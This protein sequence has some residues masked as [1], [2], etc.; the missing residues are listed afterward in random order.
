MRGGSRVSSTSGSG[1]PG[2]DSAS[3]GCARRPNG[4][5]GSRPRCLIALA[6]SPRAADVGGEAELVGELADLVV[7]VALVEAQPLR[8]LVRRAE[9][10]QPGSL[11]SVVARHLEVVAVGSVDRDADRDSVR[12]RS[13]GSAW[14]HACARSVGFGPVFSPPSGAFVI[15]PSIAS[16]S[17]SIPFSSS[18]ASS[19]R[20][21][22]QNTPASV[23]SWKRRWA[24]LK[25][26]VA[27]RVPLAARRGDQPLQRNSTAA[28]RS[29][30][31]SGLVGD[32]P[33][34]GAPR[35]STSYECRWGAHPLAAS[36][37]C[38]RPA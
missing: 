1:S 25:R 7:V 27:Q 31:A 17:Q 8:L 22:S 9:V 30:V 2:N 14:Y 13:A 33:G 20:Q 6:S 21:S 26:P 12:L 11:S 19:P 16:H 29:A 34:G 28:R 3:C 38:E 10:G 35:C 37:P 15:A 24:E 23:H 5:R 18:Y 32:A 4:G 36:E